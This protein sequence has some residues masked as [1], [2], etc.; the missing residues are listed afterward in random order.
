MDGAIFWNKI[1]LWL[2]PR[3]LMEGLVKAAIFGFCFSLICT[4]R[5]YFTTGGA[6]GVGDATHRGVVASMVL[7]IILDY[8][9]TNLL[10][11]F[12]SIWD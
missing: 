1:E 9:V 8:F 7:I 5:G 3:H 4:Y 10:M 12:F 6:K 11:I 2:E